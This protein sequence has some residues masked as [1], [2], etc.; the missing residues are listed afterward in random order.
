MW[1]R[2]FLS[3]GGEAVC[4]QARREEAVTNTKAFAPQNS[5]DPLTLGS[6]RGSC[7]PGAGPRKGQEGM[8]GRR[9]RGGFVDQVVGPFGV[10]AHCSQRC[11]AQTWGRAR[12]Q[13]TYTARKFNLSRFME[14]RM[15]RREERGREGERMD[16][17]RQ[18]QARAA[19]R[20]GWHG[21]SASGGSCPPAAQ[22]V[23]QSWLA[24]AHRGP[25]IESSPRGGRPPAT[26]PRPSHTVTHTR[27]TET[28]TWEVAG[29]GGG[30]PCPK[31]GSASNVC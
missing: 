31:E 27:M 18:Q 7:L 30:T 29:G 28:V 25:G 9:E 5:P 3:P 10:R 8:H 19:P 1:R 21:P 16:L 26:S 13:S 14:R 23:P 12:P 4:P 11:G 20:A 22:P 6:E 17:R 24:S 15:E 2:Q